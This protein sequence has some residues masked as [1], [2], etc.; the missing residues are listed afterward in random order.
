[1]EIIIS[2]LLILAIIVGFLYLKKLG[3]ST[4]NII[5][6]AIF[7]C[8]IALIT[9]ILLYTLIH[10]PMIGVPLSCLIV[11]I[12]LAVIYNKRSTQ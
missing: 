4:L 2:I 9:T 11:L 7:I 5:M 6:A 3:A 8:T 10:V 12:L 1:M